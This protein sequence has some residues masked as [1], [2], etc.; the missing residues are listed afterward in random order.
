MHPVLE[1]LVKAVPGSFIEEKEF[2]LVWHYWDVDETVADM[3]IQT[4]QDQ[5]DAAAKALHLTIMPAVKDLEISVPG[6]DKSDTAR[7]WLAREKWDFVLVAGDDTADEVLF[8]AMPENVFTIKI[9]SGKSAARYRL[10]DPQ[11]LSQLLSHFNT[12]D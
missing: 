1:Q 2:S 5:L 3:A 9:G 4:V 7:H 10:P 8:K 6:M 11:A 12:I